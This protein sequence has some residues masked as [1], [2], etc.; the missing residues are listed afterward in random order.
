LEAF[1]AKEFGDSG[2]KLGPE[3]GEGSLLW[4]H[5]KASKKPPVKK[6]FISF[7]FDISTIEIFVF[8]DFSLFLLER[9]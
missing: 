3:L 4:L 9:W 7:S 6:I 5:H 8:S 2:P 1:G